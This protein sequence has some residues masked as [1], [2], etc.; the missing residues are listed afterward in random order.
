MGLSIYQRFEKDFEGDA[1]F[2]LQFSLY[3]SRCGKAY[4]NDALKH[5]RLALSVYPESYQIIHA[6]AHMHFSLALD[7]KTSTE[8]VALME[9]A[10]DLL[11]DQI[12]KRPSDSYP[13]VT[14][15]KGR[16]KVYRKWFKD[17]LRQEAIALTGR[18]KEA[19]K[20][21]GLD[22]ELDKAIYQVGI[23]GSVPE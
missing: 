15:A 16:I 14:L 5:I 1:L 6:Y 21:P 3:E 11:E 13:L 2:Y 19:R 18:L 20:A 10:T 17:E 7:G 9:A 4:R 22:S 12:E 23:L 8:A